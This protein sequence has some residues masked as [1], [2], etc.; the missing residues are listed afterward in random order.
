MTKTEPPILSSLIEQINTFKPEKNGMAYESG[1]YDLLD[2]I[3]RLFRQR[4]LSNTVTT[5]PETATE[6]LEPESTGEAIGRNRVGGSNQ[7]SEITSDNRAILVGLDAMSMTFAQWVEYNTRPGITDD[8]HIITPPTWPP[9]GVVKAWIVT[10]V[11]AQRLLSESKPVIVLLGQCV[12]AA[13]KHIS[14]GYP[15][16]AA[17]AVLDAAGVKYVD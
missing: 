15:T 5:L 13:N 10:L 1:F 2:K 7:T 16:A 6:Q 14:T 4:G 17:K 3:N 9:I 8:S 11:R 12:K